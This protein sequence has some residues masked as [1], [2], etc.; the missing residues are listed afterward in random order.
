MSLSGSDGHIF[1][2]VNDIHESTYVELI[3]GHKFPISC[4][5][6]FWIMIKKND[7]SENDISVIIIDGIVES[8]GE[9]HHLL[10]HFSSTKKSLLMIARG[11]GEEVIATLG[12]NYNRG[13]LKAYPICAPLDVGSA[14][15]INDMAVIA[16][17]DIVSS[18]KGDLIST[19]D[20]HTIPT[21]D[22]V[23]IRKKEIVISGISSTRISNHYTYLLKK[24]DEFKFATEAH[25]IISA[26][27]KCISSLS[28][29]I[30]MG[31][32]LKNR[33]G[34]MGD[35]LDVTL[36]MIKEIA[37]YGI[38]KLET[39]ESESRCIQQILNDTESFGIREYS[40]RA[41]HAGIISGI[42]TSNLLTRALTYVIQDH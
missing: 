2:D 7:I 16:G 24:R 12:I 1:L 41:V 36:R 3:N 39:C 10:D 38:I 13:T 30:I 25:N 18:L 32:N 29:S 19:I 42:A 40:T 15:L 27:M 35:R 21:F 8:V 4:H 9:I 17:S 23:K 34:V 20:P 37:G 5:D 14:N 22:K 31:Q 26:R 11:F 6:N 28:S 33:R